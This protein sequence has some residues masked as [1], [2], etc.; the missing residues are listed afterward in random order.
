MELWV[1]CTFFLAM[2]SLLSCRFSSD[3]GDF[4]RKRLRLL[5]FFVFMKD[6]FMVWMVFLPSHFMRSIV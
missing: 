4:V 6:W 5:W 1:P 3:Q 2:D